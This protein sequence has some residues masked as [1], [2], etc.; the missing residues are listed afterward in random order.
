M[1]S[2]FIFVD[3][4]ELSVIFLQIFGDFFTEFTVHRILGVFFEFS[5]IKIRIKFFICWI[6]L[7]IQYLFQYLAAH[8]AK[9]NQFRAQQSGRNNR[10]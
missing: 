1:D 8:I 10:Q 7:K 9:A 4:T 3:L 2:L 6:S 5:Q